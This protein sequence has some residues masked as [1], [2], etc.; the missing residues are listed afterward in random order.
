MEGSGKDSRNFPTSQSFPE[1][2]KRALERIRNREKVVLLDIFTNEK[3]RSFALS[4][5]WAGDFDKK[6]IYEG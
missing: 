3:S 4:K 6:S 2:I 5:F 1:Q